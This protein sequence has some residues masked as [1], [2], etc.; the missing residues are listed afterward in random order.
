MCRQQPLIPDIWPVNVL[1]ALLK[2]AD[3]H[4]DR[5]LRKLA[6]HAIEADIKTR[7]SKGQ[8]QTLPQPLG[9]S[10]G[11]LVRRI[12]IRTGT[13]VDEIKSDQRSTHPPFEDIFAIQLCQREH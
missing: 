7:Y 13:C 12:I 4:D 11:S 8:L 6:L 3:E 2:Y 10:S 1:V 5:I 9:D